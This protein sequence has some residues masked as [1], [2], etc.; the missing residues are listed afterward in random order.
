MIGFEG[1]VVILLGVVGVSLA[2]LVKLQKEKQSLLFKNNELKAKRDVYHRETQILNERK[3]DIETKLE[4][5]SEKIILLEKEVSSL[6]SF[7]DNLKNQV[8]K[9]DSIEASLETK[10]E[11]L[12]IKVY[13]DSQERL[14]KVS[15][16]QWTVSMA[17]LKNEILHLK[18]TVTESYQKGSKETLLLTH[19]IENMNGTFETFKDKTDSLT[20]ALRGDP[21]AQGDW[22]E[23]ILQRLLESAGLTEGQEYISQG[24]GLG[25]KTE[26]GK[27][28]K[29]DMAILLPKGRNIIID[30]KVSIV[31]YEKYLA[32]E[33]EDDLKLAGKDL[34]I[35]INRH[36]D[37]LARKDYSGLYQL[38]SPDYV[39]MFIPNDGVY[40]LATSLDRE[41]FSRAIHKGVHLVS[42]SFLLP[43]LRL[44][45]NIWQGE[46]QAKNAL[47][48]AEESGKLYD[49]FVLFIQDLEK[50][51]ES[52]KKADQYSEAAFK[53]LSEGRG[54][55]VTKTEQLKLLG[56]KTKKDLN[57][58]DYPLSHTES[59]QNHLS[60][61][62]NL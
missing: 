60:N 7:N 61:E 8:K 27:I 40:A 53:K 9:I 54:S 31:S 55:L 12:M 24:K 41:L 19:Q 3:Q 48:I 10:L 39:L 36:V 13:D 44:V 23:M 22:G 56:A 29:P 58:K 51:R 34:L 20:N 21:K 46:K 17:A 6:K 25:L 28:Q 11:H 2:F 35:S 59:H 32:A 14:T 4:Q 45:Q 26:D 50:I 33:N 47:K 42:P 49:K 37:D 1:I 30:S 15:K 16:D 18:S 38:N 52:I 62:V 5:S 57:M 43:S